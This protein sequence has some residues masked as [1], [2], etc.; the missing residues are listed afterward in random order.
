MKM[1]LILTFILNCLSWAQEGVAEKENQQNDIVAK[2]NGN[3]GDE[4]LEDAKEKELNPDQK[5][6][7]KKAKAKVKRR[8]ERL[9]KIV[10]RE[11]RI[12][13]RTMKYST[14][15]EDMSL[16]LLSSYSDK[17]RMVKKEENRN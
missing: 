13:E 7:V 9:K 12:A 10:E 3:V 15:L 11:L 17:M 16:R 6:K 5:K 14:R 1:I 2:S 8:E 4:E